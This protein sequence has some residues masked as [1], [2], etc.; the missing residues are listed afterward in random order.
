MPR[1][2]TA[3]LLVSLLAGGCTSTP[4]P[5][6]V[7]VRG[8]VLDAQKKPVAGVIVRFWPSDQRG[9]PTDMVTQKDGAFE[10]SCLPGK[11]HV[12]LMNVPAQHGADPASGTTPDPTKSKGAQAR[13]PPRLTD[14]NKTPWRDIDVP[15]EGRNGLELVIAE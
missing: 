15:G 7:P 11:Y 8:M 14:V 5:R 1:R 12:T 3:L 4:P 2:S 6:P 10:L 13:I 9:A